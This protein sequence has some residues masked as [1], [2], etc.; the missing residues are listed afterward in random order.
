[1]RH[2]AGEDQAAGGQRRLDLL[3]VDGAP[4]QLLLAHHHQD[5]VLGQVQHR[6]GDELQPA[7]VDDHA[8][9]EHDLLVLADAVPGA[10]PPQRPLL[11]ADGLVVVHDQRLDAGAA[12]LDQDLR[13]AL[14]L[15]QHR[16]HVALEHEAFEE[17]HDRVR[18]GDLFAVE[19]EGEVDEAHP[20]EL[21]RHAGPE[22]RLRAAGDHH[23]AIE[24]HEPGE[25]AQ[26]DVPG[27]D[28]QPTDVRR[29][30]QHRAPGLDALVGE[31][32][33]TR[34]G[35]EPQPLEAREPPVCTGLG[36][37]PLDTLAG[38]L[39]LDRVPFELVPHREGQVHVVL[40]ALLERE[41]R[42]RAVGRSFLG[43]VGA[44]D[45]RPPA[46]VDER[47]Q[48]QHDERMQGVLT[49]VGPDH[50]TRAAVHAHR[51]FSAATM[52]SAARPSPKTSEPADI[53]R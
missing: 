40:H 20:L 45:R 23:L 12:L 35:L 14:V 4:L 43:L 34:L 36:Q 37:A 53:C 3:G 5:H 28:R 31:E 27:V 49:V 22:R 30:L 29:P 24:L 9:V 44:D 39:D 46:L 16:V 42:E 19:L 47:L 52:R 48:P 21:G 7:A 18:L 38:A 26:V 10:Q 25:A 17:G 13:P 1:M 32:Q 8:L 33:P 6:L 2:R 50:A 11:G 41:R 51:S 15:G